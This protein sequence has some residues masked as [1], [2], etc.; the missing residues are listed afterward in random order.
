MSTVA[1][2]TCLFRGLRVPDIL[3]CIQRTALGVKDCARN[4]RDNLIVKNYFATTEVQKTTASTYVRVGEIYEGVTVMDQAVRGLNNR[5]QQIDSD[6]VELKDFISEQ[7]KDALASKNG[8]FQMLKDVVSGK[9]SSC[10]PID[11]DTYP[12]QAFI[13]MS[14]KNG[15]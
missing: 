2:V 11:S 1:K 9:Q 4:L 5:C 6:I 14:S 3:D 15:R 13:V 12:I 8:L 10:M 7:I